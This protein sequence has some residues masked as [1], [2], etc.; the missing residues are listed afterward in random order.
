MN[1]E[2]IVRDCSD[3][4]RADWWCCPVIHKRAPSRW[5]GKHPHAIDDDCERKYHLEED[6]KKASKC[7][8]VE[9]A[10]QRQREQDEDTNADLVQYTDDWATQKGVG[11]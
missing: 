6:G 2:H 7:E 9:V 8:L 5:F 10:Q 3:H 11:I 4:F 1:T